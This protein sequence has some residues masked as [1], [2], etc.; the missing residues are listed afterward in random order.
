MVAG[1]G[2]RCA[3]RRLDRLRRDRRGAY[4]LEYALLF[5]ALVLVL[6]ACLE[7]A[8]QLVIATA[9]DHGARQASRSAALGPVGGVQT[10]STMLTRILSGAGLPLVGWEAEPPILTAQPFASY[11]ALAA[12]PPLP[13][14]R[15]CPGVPSWG[16]TMGGSAGIVRYCV[17]F[18]ARSFTPLGALVPALYQH[19]AFFVV[20]NEP[21]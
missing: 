6:A 17:H 1:L 21:Y 9:L 15:S 20:Q 5:N 14:D 7:G 8:L 4:L 11:P 12:A 2:L 13:S 16:D 19:R 10:S 18:R 3:L